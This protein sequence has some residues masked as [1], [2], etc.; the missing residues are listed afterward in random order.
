MKKSQEPGLIYNLGTRQTNELN[1]YYAVL[2][3][4]PI[5]LEK[6][7]YNKMQKL[8]ILQGLQSKN[9]TFNSKLTEENSFAYQATL[10]FHPEVIKLQEKANKKD[11]ELLNDLQATDGENQVRMEFEVFE[12]AAVNL[13]PI[14]NWKEKT[15][16]TDLNVIIN[17]E[18]IAKFDVPQKQVSKQ[19]E[20]EMENDA[21]EFV[22]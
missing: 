3:D 11:P 4:R 10:R 17:G 6:I 12:K 16:E 18:G 7:V 13:T 14:G 2:E 5:Q 15:F 9:P 8:D 19:E 21:E 22:K 1:K 20:P